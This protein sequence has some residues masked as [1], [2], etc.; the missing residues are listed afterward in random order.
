[1]TDDTRTY[2]TRDTHPSSRLDATSPE[3]VEQLARQFTDEGREFARITVVRREPP[4][5]ANVGDRAL[6]TPDGDLVGWIGGVNCAQSV[7]IR[8]AK[9]ALET[10]DS[11]LVG[12]APDPETI[13][14]PGLLS[15]P[16]T[17]HSGGT[18]E[19]FIEPVRPTQ[20]VVVLGDTVV[21]QSLGR[22][23]R[24]LTYDVTVVTDP[25]DVDDGEL[26]SAIPTGSYVVVATMGGFDESGLEAA[27]RAEPAY[28]GLVASTTRAEELFDRVADRLGTDTT[29]VEASVTVPAGLD[30]GAKT[31]EEIA[32][33]ILAEVVSVRR[34]TDGVG[35]ET[36]HG[37]TESESTDGSPPKTAIDPV[38][39]MEV[40]VGE[41]AAAVDLN[42]T[43]YYFCGQGC[44]DAFQKDP[45]RFVNVTEEG[46][47]S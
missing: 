18:L 36:T 5:S 17:C 20:R 4:V 27:I 25:S 32:V 41:E 40:T 7:A 37:P 2:D 3:R 46:F 6:L 24:E 13:A 39:G 12:L 9:T 26:A 31:P 43:T 29:V 1:M 30:I 47:A 35:S 42:G 16:M 44:A 11:V 45:G 15:F 14:R 22:L 8:E 38:C 33:S 10:G 19:L 28:V 34:V 23:A 21:A